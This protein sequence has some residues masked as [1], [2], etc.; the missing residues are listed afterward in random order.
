MTSAVTV[1]SCGEDRNQDSRK[2]SRGEGAAMGGTPS[3]KQ[4]GYMGR[5]RPKGLCEEGVCARL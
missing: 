1:Q 4:G 2:H 3:V 5:K